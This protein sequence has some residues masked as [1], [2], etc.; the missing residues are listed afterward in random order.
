MRRRNGGGP[1]TWNGSGS[2]RGAADV[3]SPLTLT[4]E[5][6]PMSFERARRVADSVLLEGYLLYPYRSSSA[7]NQYRW[8]FGVLAPRVLSEGAGFDPWRMRVACLIEGSS[9]TVRARLRFLQLQTCTIE[10]KTPSGYQ[11][12]ERLEVDGQ[13]HLPWEEG[14]LRELDF[15]LSNSTR[16][17]YSRRIPFKID[18]GSEAEPITDSHGEVV[19]RM[20]RTRAPLQGTMSFTLERVEHG[21]E[22]LTRISVGIENL[23]PS[24][25]KISSRSDSLRACLASTHVLLAVRDGAFLSAIDPP[26]YA[27]GAS[28]RCVREGL[29]PVLAGESGCFELMLLSPIILYDHPEIAPES[30]GDFFDACEIDEWLALR[31]LTLTP[32]ENKLARATDERAA[33][34]LDRVEI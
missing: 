22:P 29:F 15:Q 3:T 11:P 13:V 27:A 7:K 26:S 30:P 2:A 1:S 6:L 9:P 18:A 34:L 8:T 17:H 25:G 14:V 19:G 28:Q 31:P 5:T 20:L 21:L 32:G 4:D 16:R 12:A 24:T 33:Q 10:Q 23:T